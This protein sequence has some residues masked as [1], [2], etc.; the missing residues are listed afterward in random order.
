MT[1][2]GEYRSRDLI[3]NDTGRNR[4]TGFR[5]FLSKKEYVIILLF[6]LTAL[7]LLYY[8][9]FTPNYY[10]QASPLLFEVRRGQPLNSI[11]ENMYQ[12]G[13]IHSKFNMKVAA[14]LYG[15]ERKIRAG[16]YYIPNGQSYLDL[17][18][19]FLYGNADFLREVKIFDGSSLEWIAS[20]L[21]IDASIDSAAFVTMIK[22]KSYL[23]KL[24]VNI[25]SLNGYLLPDKYYFYQRS[26]PEEV[27]DTFYYRFRSFFTDSIKNAAAKNNLDS[28]EVIILA[29]IVEGETN[30]YKEM[31]LIAGVYL[32]RMQKGMK[33][34]ADPTVQYLQE[35][36]WK[37]LLIKDLNIDSPYNTYKYYGLPPGPINNPGKKA[38]LAV[39]YPEHHNYYYFVADGEGGHKFART[40]EEHNR[41]V[42][43]YRK[44]LRET[45]KS[46]Q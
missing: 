7:A 23:R 22:D 9:F 6:F 30:N 13:I 17:L 46:D 45:N 12:Q 41:N 3:M 43:Q 31:P 4:K 42:L 26:S 37:R 32:N 8:T 18:D 2:P 24:G 28:N 39:V 29:S 33:L 35:G 21:R 19:T 16:R 36:G 1:N 38:I 34:Q 40:L 11:I 27:I 20:K 14:F 5:Q 25:F 10:Q 44:Y 15:A